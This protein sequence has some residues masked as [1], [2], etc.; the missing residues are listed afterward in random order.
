LAHSPG[1]TISEVDTERNS[2]MGSVNV[3]SQ[4]HPT[5]IIHPF[6]KIGEGVKIG[7]YSVIGEHV[8]LG[9]GCEVGSNVL[10]DGWTRIGRNNVFFHGASIGTVPQDLKYKGDESYVE[11][12]D[13]NT[14]REFITVN[15]GTNEG[16]STIIGSGC[17]LM[18]YVHIAHNCI[19]G[20]NVILANAVNL[21]GHVTID[22]YA[23]VGGVT[24]VHQFVRIGKYAFVGGGSRIE[25]DI[26][27]FIKVAGNP[28]RVYGI[29][30]LGLE[31][32][33][34]SLESKMMLKKMFHLLNR[35]G[36]N[37]SQVIE[38]MKNGNFKDPEKTIFVEFLENTERGITK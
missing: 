11:I 31:R 13:G 29:N 25:Q 8:V 15:S 3:N 1:E 12:G 18:A 19:I 23:T 9:D 10:L 14:F 17:L 28:V 32:H 6:A 7:P 35:S 16:E 36:L 34:F 24:P 4:I 27:P 37:V 30:S 2:E 26:P 33:G 38:Q 21:A 20:N 22:D 5:A